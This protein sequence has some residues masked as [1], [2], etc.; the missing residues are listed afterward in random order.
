[1]GISGARRSAP[2][3]VSPA[4]ALAADRQLDATS[5]QGVVPEPVPPIRPVRWRKSVVILVPSTQPR[6]RRP[7]TN[8]SRE[9]GRTHPD[10]SSPTRTTVAIRFACC[11]PPAENGAS[12][13]LNCEHDREPD[14][15]H[16]HLNSEGWR[17][18]SRP[19]DFA[20]WGWV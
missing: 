9:F 1:M 3:D 19:L 15:P 5:A 18:S 14:P 12:A 4:A 11:A 10:K 20:P 8:V 7:C 17:E 2:N 6:P 16:G 13:R